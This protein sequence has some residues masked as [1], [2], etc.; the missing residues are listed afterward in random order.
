MKNKEYFFFQPA[1]NIH[2]IRQNVC[3]KDI[4]K[5]AATCWPPRWTNAVKEA[6]SVARRQRR[7]F[8]PDNH[9]QKRRQFSTT[10][11]RSWVGSASSSS[12]VF[13]YWPDAQDWQGLPWT[14]SVSYICSC[15]LLEWFSLRYK[16]K[17]TTKSHQFNFNFYSVSIPSPLPLL[18]DTHTLLCP[19]PPPHTHT[20]TP[21]TFP[22]W[23]RVVAPNSV[24][25]TNEARLVWNRY[26]TAVYLLRALIYCQV[27]LLTAG[28]RAISFQQQWQWHRLAELYH[29][30]GRNGKDGGTLE[31]LATAEQESL[32]LG[33]NGRDQSFV[34]EFSKVGEVDIEAGER[35]SSSSDASSGFC[36]SQVGTE[37]Q[38][39]EFLF[40]NSFLLQ[41][42]LTARADVH[43]EPREA[44]LLR[45]PTSSLSSFA[46][47]T[48]SFAPTN[49][50]FSA[51]CNSYGSTNNSFTPATMV[52]S[53]N[54]PP[55][56]RDEAPSR[57]QPLTPG[58]TCTRIPLQVLQGPYQNN[59]FLPDPPNF[60]DEYIE[61]ISAAQHVL[62]AFPPTA[63]SQVHL[64]VQ[65][66]L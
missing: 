56:H 41:D 38:F 35:S 12:K 44:S 36:G 64:Q 58:P 14:R 66:H 15:M 46:P 19:R 30:L 33:R 23:L 4:L 63:Q 31:R 22:W 37:R 45:R 43:S 27:I 20:H 50:S 13:V 62:R 49:N 3:K 26:C 8:F 54:S 51:N 29:T 57:I 55:R 47:A 32:T 53:N 21:K 17:T 48:N 24:R 60:V 6:A 28:S 18:F 65:Q 61:R 7:A 2:V 52:R 10:G 11:E 16:T 25:R 1:A 40:N 5:Q 59:G 9:D 42:L 39:F 34:D